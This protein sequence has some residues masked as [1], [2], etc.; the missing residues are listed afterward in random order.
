MSKMKSCERK[1]VSRMRVV[2][3]RAELS[4][5]RSS[6]TESKRFRAK[7]LTA[8]IKKVDEIERSEDEETGVETSE[9]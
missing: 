5:K 3:Q 4:E 9:T 8:L 7:V 2:G 6:E 1:S